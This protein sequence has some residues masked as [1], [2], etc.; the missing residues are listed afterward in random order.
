MTRKPGVFERRLARFTAANRLRKSNNLKTEAIGICEH[1]L[2]P[3]IVRETV[4][5]LRDMVEAPRAK[6][7]ARSIA[8]RKGSP[9]CK[10]HVPKLH[11][12]VADFL[13]R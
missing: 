7:V 9:I 4:P 8:G 13:L 3:P 12:G 10:F 11:R 6:P 2:V 1:K 5:F